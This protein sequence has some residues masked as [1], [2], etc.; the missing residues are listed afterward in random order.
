[1]I[2]ST[3][4]LMIAGV[5]VPAGT[6]ALYTVPGARAWE[7]IVNRSHRQWG[8]EN[9]Y[10]DSV[11]AM[12]VGRGRVPAARA[13]AYVEQFTIRAEAARGDAATLVLEWERTRVAIPVARAR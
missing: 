7:I 2:H 12:E 9:A 1:M 5:R 4:D 13:D 11:R 3:A 8:H 10:T 6:H